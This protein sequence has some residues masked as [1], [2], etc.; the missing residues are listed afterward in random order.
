M[1]DWKK[2]RTEY[3]TGNTSYRKLA[4]KY[5]T[6]YS[7]ICEKGKAENWVEQRDQYRAKTMAKTI[8]KSCEIQSDKL[9]RVNDLADRLM[10]KL[11]QAIG[12]LDKAIVIHRVK[13]ETGNGEEVTERKE[14]VGGGIVDRVGLRQLTAALK[15]LKEV[16]MLR[17]ELDKREQEARIASLEKQSR[18]EDPG[19]GKITVV[20]EGA[21]SDYAG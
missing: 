1:A 10:D 7:V 18:E 2:I 12:E 14:A 8:E 4:Q 20:L 16:Q 3:I 15:D 21:L 11:E 6:S 17:S 9:A 5:S 19:K 13:V